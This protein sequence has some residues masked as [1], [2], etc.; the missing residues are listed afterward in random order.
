[1]KKNINLS[2]RLMSKDRV[3]VVKRRM[4]CI[5]VSE[6]TQP[7]FVVCKAIRSGSSNAL[8]WSVA[9]LTTALDLVSKWWVFKYIR[10]EEN[11]A[12]IPEYLYFRITKNIG[13]VFGM[14]AGKVW[15][16][17]GASLIA[18]IFIIQLFSQSR[19]KQPGFHLL[20]ALTLGGAI[21]NLYDR[22]I[23]GFVRDFIYVRIHAAGHELWPW[24][25]NI[26]DMALVI[27]VAGLL[28]GWFFG[29]FEIGE[30]QSCPVA[31]PL[32]PTNQDS[33]SGDPTKPQ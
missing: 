12:I 21:G 28:L 11:L 23:H 9:V 1:M 8:F 4:E 32:S 14:G 31:R 10:P 18:M 15:L 19:A 29:K 2:G 25:F 13:A 26:A 5:D 33:T 22:A 7:E 17:M 30:T 20:L 24:V 6:S 16:F 27:G 3:P